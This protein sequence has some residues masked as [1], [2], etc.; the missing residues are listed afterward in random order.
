MLRRLISAFSWR[1][2]SIPI[3]LKILGI[4]FLTAVLF[5]AITLLQTRASTSQIF[6]QLLEQRTLSMGRSLADTIER[7]ASTGDFF[8]VM[9]HLQQAQKTFPEIRYII[10]RNQEGKVV[11]STF[12]Q[13]VPADLVIKRATLVNVYSRELCPKTSIFI[14][15]SR[16]ASVGE[17]EPL[18]GPQTVVIRKGKGT[19]AAL[20]SAE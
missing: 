14:K 17:Y 7:P 12:G 8:S 3:F 15:G 19:L 2:L 5:S 10:V 9:E 1:I 4:G 13:K 6:Y 11:A 20:G 16:I 18:V